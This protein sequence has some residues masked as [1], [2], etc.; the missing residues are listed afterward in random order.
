MECNRKNV[1]ELADKFWSGESSMEEEAALS[2][3]IS[4]DECPEELEG[5]AAY[6]AVLEEDGSLE[7][8]SDFDDQIMA[9]IDKKKKP[10]FSLNPNWKFY[11]AAAV[12]ALVFGFYFFGQGGED[13]PLAEETPV[14]TEYTQQEIDEAFEQTKSAMLLISN[15][16]NQGRQHTVH[17]RKMDSA[18]MLFKGSEK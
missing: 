3:F 10:V 15:K 1:F 7:L 17:I 4:S 5:L 2:K 11:A 16:I 18:T 6:F 14:S 12:I 9:E 13:S 8:G